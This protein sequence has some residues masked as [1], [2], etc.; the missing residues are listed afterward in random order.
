MHQTY[1][2]ATIFFY[3]LSCIC[4]FIFLE[5]KS[6]AFVHISV[7]SMTQEKHNLVSKLSVC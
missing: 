6:E 2:V 5:H 1:S 7:R 4:K 3:E